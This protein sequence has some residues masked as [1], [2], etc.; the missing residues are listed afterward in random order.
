MFFL[1]K[2]FGVLGGLPEMM[3]WRSS[4]FAGLDGCQ[5]GLLAGLDGLAETMALG[6]MR[7]PKAARKTDCWAGLIRCCFSFCGE[8]RRGAMGSWKMVWQYVKGFNAWIRESCE[9]LLAH[10]V[11]DH[12]QRSGDHSQQGVPV[13]I[14][15]RN[16][17]DGCGGTVWLLRKP[18]AAGKGLRGC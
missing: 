4:R 8:W 9:A 3:V 5:T 1:K 11:L 14:V 15:R 10:W 17:L 6:E 12:S 2:P 7:G 13:E 16:N 18:I